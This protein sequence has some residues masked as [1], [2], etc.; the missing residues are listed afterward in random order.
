M[1]RLIPC[2]LYNL[3]LSLVLAGCQAALVPPVQAVSTPA[4]AGAATLEVETA[5]A[6]AEAAPAAE[7]VATAAPILLPTPTPEPTVAPPAEPTA[8]PTAAPA[9][10]AEAGAPA[11][12]S[13]G[14]PFTVGNEL[15]IAALLERDIQGSAVTIEQQLENGANYARYIASYISEGNKIYGLLTVP[16]GDPPP[17]GF[18]AIVFNHGYIPPDQYRTT[19]RYVAY[20]DALA[21]SGFVVF[22]IDLRGFGDS[23]GEPEGS[24]F[25]P[26][27][28]I[29]AI[30]ALKS[31]QTLPYVDPEGIGMWGHSMAGNL[32]LRAMLI[33]PA[34]GAGVIWAGAVYSY[35][36]FS[37]Y[38]IEDPSYVPPAAETP[39]R[40]IGRL[41]R[42]TYGPPDMTQPYWQAV[43]LTEH[44]DLLSAPVQLH[45]ALNDTV[46]TAGY[47]ADLAAVLNAAGKPYEYYPYDGGGHNIES[48]YFNEAI[49][50]TI[51]FFRA[52][53]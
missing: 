24:Y 43:S 52:N 50:R 26:A 47:S 32:V 34:I 9:A 29:D 33:E 35:D 53:L 42:E 1:K 7:P 23:E 8:A 46:V 21:R 39:G 31:L 17:G 41:I 38:S 37:R 49:Q 15:T 6:A 12:V 4:V 25:S 13:A 2:L 40:R 44:I 10:Q 51:E 48:P 5:P 22:K 18:K 27:Y 11:A 19:E 30:S 28:T 45:H 20:V 16:F 3:I 14:T 36:D